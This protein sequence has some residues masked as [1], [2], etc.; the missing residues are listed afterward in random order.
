MKA[1]LVVSAVLAGLLVSTVGVATSTARSQYQGTA[2]FA[3]PPGEPGNYILPFMPG[4]LGN[5]VDIFQFQNLLWQPLY[6]F[7]K[8][9][10]QG[11]NYG[12]SV[13]KPPVFSNGGRTV[14]VTMNQDYKWSDGQPVTNRDV[15]F[16]MNIFSAEKTNYYAYF[17]G[18]LPDD[19]T[20]MSFPA[21]TPYQFSITFNKAY[22]HLWVLYNQLSEIW[23]IPQQTWDKTSENGPVG[24]YDE[25]TAGA[26]A[27]YNF[28]NSQATDESTYTDS[29][30]RA[31]DGPWVVQAFSPATG[32]ATFVPNRQFTG[33]DKPHLA[34][35][36]EVPFTSDV[37]EFDALRSG[38]LDYGYLPTQ[39]ISQEKYFTS[40][41]YKV[42]PWIDF[43][44]NSF[45]LNFTSP[46][47]GSIFKQLYIR[48]ALQELINQP[49][50]VKDIYHGQAYPDYGPVPAKPAN[51]YTDKIGTDNPY[52]YSVTNAE[53]TLRSHGWTVHPKG[54]DVCS[55]PGDG[56]GECGTGVARGAELKFS[57]L[58]ATGSAPFTA[59]VEAIQSA[60]SEAGIEVTLKSEP[61]TQIFATME[62]CSDGGVG[63]SWEIG[64]FGA[65]GSTP[66]YSP[67]YLPL[68]T[69]WFAAGGGTNAG[70]YDNPKMNAIIAN[71]TTDSA[72]SA[73]RAFGVYAAEDLPNLWLPD[74]PYQLSVVSPKLKGALPQDPNLNVYPQNWTLSQ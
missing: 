16:W 29:L 63:C 44:F 18:S 28:L 38:E 20:S 19:I 9:L 65:P 70:G 67:E 47:V 2:T 60:W 55:K 48:Q 50:I 30:W 5:N 12:L 68:G 34:A 58:V 14:T 8:G 61:E 6:W 46:T 41:G 72:V 32:A 21:S 73:I 45:W 24:N 25:T 36:E 31:V 3:L 7:G 35:F 1:K 43:G 53:K 17:E 52:P 54:V 71:A 37:A 40:R 51:P 74:Y 15:E 10:D 11:I 42:A 4:Y 62:P 64:N 33:P 27:V 49:Q 13:G 57:E 39:D 69:Q 56:P 23:P 59:E 66:T 22:S 26:E